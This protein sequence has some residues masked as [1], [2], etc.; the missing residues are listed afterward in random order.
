[1]ITEHQYFVYILSTRKNK[2]LYV[3]V[4]NDLKRR[5]F[6]HV[7]GKYEGYTRRYQVHYLLYF[8]EFKYID[9][10]INREKELKGW[11]RKKKLALIKSKNP[12]LKFLNEEILGL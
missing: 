4:T 2:L 12:Q 5:L 8:E 7:S 3:G 9:Q 1:M 6:E 10:A 11:I